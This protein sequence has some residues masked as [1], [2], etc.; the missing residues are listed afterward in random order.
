MET[1]SHC[2]RANMLAR[3]VALT[4]KQAT[5]R[6]FVYGDH[7][8]ARVDRIRARLRLAVTRAWNPWRYRR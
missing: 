7:S 8:K 6:K 4:M 1:K 5:D 3:E 2:V